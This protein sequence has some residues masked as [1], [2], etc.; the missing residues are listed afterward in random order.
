MALRTR[1]P[2]GIPAYPIILIEGPEKVGKSY[3][4]FALSASEKVGRTFV[5]EI[6]ER[7]ADEYAALG[8]Y[9]VVELDGTWT[10]FISQFEAATIEPA[11]DGRP[12][13]I[14]ID[15]AT[16]LWDSLKDWVGNR[17]ANSNANRK[18][19]ADDPDAAITIGNNLWNDANSRWGKL[20]R[21][22]RSHPGP[23]VFTARS[24][25]NAKISASGAPIAGQTEYKVETQKHLPNQASAV[26]RVEA[27]GVLSLVGTWSLD[28]DTPQPLPAV[29]T[30]EHLVFDIIG[31]G[32]FDHRAGHD[33]IYGRVTD[34]AKAQ[35]LD[36][37]T[38]AGFDSERAKSAAGAVWRS[39]ECAGLER[40]AEV[41]DTQ[42]ADLVAAAT[43]AIDDPEPETA[44]P[45]TPGGQ[46]A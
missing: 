25:M 13:V 23:V 39:S 33:P 19:L 45:V 6:G 44:A 17:A 21:L 8:P 28:V 29:A 42:W 11:E 9:E 40:G 3:A 46:E 7:T 43:V 38:D 37:F 32:G 30:L 22:A 41:S 27:P 34:D 24:K 10:D 12:N 2:T 1:K 20:I 15:S 4:A 14:V 36:L 18:L 35:L 26:V 5:F 31:A 16:V